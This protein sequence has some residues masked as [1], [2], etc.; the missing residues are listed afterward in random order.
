MITVFAT[1]EGL[2]G[3]KTATGWRIDRTVP[4]VALPSNA[5]VHL[6]VWVTNP[7]NGKR[8]R[9]LVLDVGPHYEHDTAYVFGGARPR[10]EAR[11]YDEYGRVVTNSAGIDL[12]ELVW[13]TLGYT[14]NG[15]CQWE[16]A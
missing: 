3:D 11:G 5:A 4:F 8:V 9:A 13:K 14:D 2:V 12:G 1:R 15:P 7:A 16:F 6:W 10:A